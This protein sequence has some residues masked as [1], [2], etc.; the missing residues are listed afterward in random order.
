MPFINIP[1]PYNDILLLPSHRERNWEGEASRVPKKSVALR[2]GV[3]RGVLA[4][5]LR[6]FYGVFSVFRGFLRFLP[7]LGLNVRGGFS[8]V[9]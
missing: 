2:R 7:S 5:F 4:G 8:G 3:F 6:R 9:F 1:P